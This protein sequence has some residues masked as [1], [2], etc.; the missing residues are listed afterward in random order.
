MTIGQGTAGQEDSSSRV[1]LIKG[2][3]AKRT[4]DQRPI[5]K[6]DQRPLHQ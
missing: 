2:S 5:N 4:V 1:L 3:F 6:S